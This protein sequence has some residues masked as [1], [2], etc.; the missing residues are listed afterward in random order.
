MF[1]VANYNSIQNF[2]RLATSLISNQTQL[3]PCI[4]K[5]L[6]AS[7]R[8]Q[9]LRSFELIFAIC[10]FS[11][12]MVY[13]IYYIGQSMISFDVNTFFPIL[14]VAKISDVYLE[15]YQSSLKKLF[16]KEVICFCLCPEDTPKTTQG[17]VFSPKLATLQKRL[18]WSLRD[19]CTCFKDC[20]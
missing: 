1:P 6:Q 4:D 20:N 11:I 19:V 18:L 3:N 10:P 16:A 17:Q 2:H 13:F 14:N 12:S 8:Y 9:A 7:F 5:G 15:P